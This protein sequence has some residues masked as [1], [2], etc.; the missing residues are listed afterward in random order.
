M[1][2]PETGSE[3]NPETHRDAVSMCSTV[4]RIKVLVDCAEIGERWGFTRRKGT[5]RT[6]KDKLVHASGRVGDLEEIWT[7]LSR[8]CLC[9][10][11]A[12]SGNEDDLRGGACCANSGDC[13]LNGVGPERGALRQIVGLVPDMSRASD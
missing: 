8:E 9:A 11:V 7:G 5:V 10:S 13:G 6:V 4:I 3:N 12:G 2:S 1:V